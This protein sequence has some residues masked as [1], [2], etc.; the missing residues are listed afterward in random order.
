MPDCGLRIYAALN[1]DC[2][3]GCG[4]DSK[5]R[6]PQSAIRNHM[7]HPTAIISSRARLGANVTVGPYSIIGDHVTIHEDVEIA[8]H[9][10]VEGPC[11][12]GEGTRIYPF[13]SVGQ[14]PQDLK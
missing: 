13:A 8:G 2:A 7:I 11:E 5:I 14:P 12:I 4:P 3:A 1:P 6:I 10:V 9:V